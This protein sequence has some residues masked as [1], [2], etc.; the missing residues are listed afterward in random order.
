MIGRVTELNWE[1]RSPNKVV[2]GFY[3]GTNYVTAE[4]SFNSENH[5]IV[6]SERQHFS[7]LIYR[8]WD[9]A[10][11]KT[12]SQ[13]QARENMKFMLSTGKL[14]IANQARESMQPVTNAKSGKKWPWRPS[15]QNQCQAR[16]MYQN[17]LLPFKRENKVR[18]SACLVT[19]DFGLVL[20]GWK[21]NMLTLIG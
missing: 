21:R 4:P 16:E 14:T 1:N 3:I 9:F 11:A 15:A 17:W 20:I 7:C 18:G 19:V 2:S 5:L 6:K 13:Y 8:Q 10:T 12:D